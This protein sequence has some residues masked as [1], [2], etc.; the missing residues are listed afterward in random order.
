MS[1]SIV[2]ILFRLLLRGRYRGRAAAAAVA[3]LLPGLAAC[4]STSPRSAAA[5]PSSSASVTST[6]APSLSAG[7]DLC[8]VVPSSTVTAAFG[9]NVPTAQPVAFLGNPSCTYSVKASNLGADGGIQVANMV[10]WKAQNYQ[11]AKQ[12]GLTGGEAPVGV[13]LDA[14]KMKADVVALA[15]T[16]AGR[17]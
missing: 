11:V 17:V 2:S 3:L 16:V 6:A 5:S 12:T 14:A 1:A 10:I 4:S 13:V 9:G 7:S 15:K 8:A